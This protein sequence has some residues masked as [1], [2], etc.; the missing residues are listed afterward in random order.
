MSY[1]A[2]LGRTPPTVAA[3]DIRAHDLDVVSRHPRREIVVRRHPQEASTTGSE[4]WVTRRAAAGRTRGSVWRYAAVA[5][6]TARQH[7]PQGGLPLGEQPRERDG[8]HRAA[9]APA[10]L[11]QPEVATAEVVGR[12]LGRRGAEDRAA[13]QLAAGVHRSTDQHHQDGQ[14]HR[15]PAGEGEHE[16]AGGED[17]LGQP[18][19]PAADAP[20]HA[21]Y[22]ESL[23]EPDEHGV[24]GEDRADD[25]PG[26]VDRLGDV[27]R[28]GE[29]EHHHPDHEAELGDHEPEVGP[30]PQHDPPPLDRSVVGLRDA[31][32]G[33]VE[34][35]HE[36]EHEGHGVD[37]HD[38]LVRGVR[39]DLQRDAGQH[40][41]HR[42]AE[43]AHRLEEAEPQL[44]LPR[45]RD[46]GDH[47]AEGPP[48]GLPAEV[49]QRGPQRH[50]EERVGPEVGH[51]PGRLHQVAREHH[52]PRAEAVDEGAD[53]ERRG[54]A[55]QRRERQRRAD[56]HEGQ[57]G[58]RE[59][60]EQRDGHEEP[61]ADGV[62]DDRGHE[63]PVLADAGESETGEHPDILTHLTASVLPV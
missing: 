31:V 39:T 55:E 29:V 19:H 10:E 35:Q 61:A 27:D 22:D 50:G 51:H 54:H 40:A 20:G 15:Q 58:H 18:H 59:E 16:V 9:D 3:H 43:V 56:L 48:E 12:G 26:Q 42:E 53:D 21:A 37:H 30:V 17:Q 4:R 34:E 44:A 2:T 11:E 45:G 49:E 13:D 6:A 60:V 52:L 1:A 7:P 28:Q 46:G 33:H 62:G 36:G 14:P 5:S 23:P 24:Q 32:V 8:R 57:V 63:P 38:G 47:V 25:P 41:A